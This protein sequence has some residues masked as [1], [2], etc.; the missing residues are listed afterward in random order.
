MRKAV[1]YKNLKNIF[2]LSLLLFSNFYLFANEDDEKKE[3]E[4]HHHEENEKL[5]FTIDEVICL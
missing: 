2:I 5:S 1:S 4:S 3:S